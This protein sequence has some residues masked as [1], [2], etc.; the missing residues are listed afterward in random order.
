MDA[1]TRVTKTLRHETPDRPATDYNA[2]SEVHEQL[3]RHFGFETV[4]QIEDHFKCDLRWVYPRYTG[5]DEFSGAA[6][7]SAEGKDFLGIVWRP[8]K[9][10]YATYNEIAVSPLAD[11]ESVEDIETY[12]WPTADW[13]D[14]SHLKEEIKRINDKERHFICFFAGGAFETPW[15][16]R[17]MENFL[18]D[19]VLQPEIAEAI[20]RKAQEFYKSRALKALEQSDGQ[21]DMIGSGGDIGTQRGMMISPDIWRKHI[22]PHSKELIRS[23]K[24]MG[25]YTFYHSCGSIVPVIEDLIEIGLD[26][27]DPVQIS[28]DGMD[29]EYLKTN[30]GGNLS[31]HGGVDEQTMLPVLTP[32][33]LEKKIIDLIDILGR[34]GGFIPCA[35]HAIQPDTPIEN[36]ITMYTTIGNYRYS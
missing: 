8:V 2:T 19:L 34:E 36:I 7:V 3:F 14:F 28:A 32:D 33:R 35:A 11:A 25:Y 9:N 20:S 23:F 4:N 24:D 10:K 29:P 13:F 15:Y 1:Y 30:F 16:M 22:K 5:P 31:F 26:V 12:P 6:G 21:I 27:L 18:T 17:G